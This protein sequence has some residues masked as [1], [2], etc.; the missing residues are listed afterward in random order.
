M[1]ND[2]AEGVVQVALWDSRRSYG[3]NTQTP[4]NSIDD[5]LSAKIL[6]FLHAFALSPKIQDSK[7]SA[8]NV[9]ITYG[10]VRILLQGTAIPLKI[11]LKGP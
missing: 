9:S 3:M 7:V 5:M 10:A 6:Q 8:V 4:A 2:D 1:G 11:S